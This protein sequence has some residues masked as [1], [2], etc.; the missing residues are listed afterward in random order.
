[1]NKSFRYANVT[2][3][4]DD[5]LLL[6]GR[7]VLHSIVVNAAPAAGRTL[8]LYDNTAASSPIIASLV[9]LSTSIDHPQTAIYDVEFKTGLHVVADGALDV[10]IAYG[11]L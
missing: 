9:L 6:T 2:G 11:K 10:T 4:S 7:G 3:T 1:M 8:V 5:G